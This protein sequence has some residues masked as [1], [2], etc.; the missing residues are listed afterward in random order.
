MLG[1]TLINPFTKKIFILFTLL[2]IFPSNSGG[3]FL[4]SALGTFAQNATLSNEGEDI[5][6]NSQDNL[7]QNNTS[8][9]ASK[10][11]VDLAGEREEDL[12][13][14]TNPCEKQAGRLQVLELN[15][16]DITDVS[17]DVCV[18]SSIHE[19]YGNTSIV[20]NNTGSANISSFLV[21]T[22]GR[23]LDSSSASNANITLLEDNFLL[24]EPI[25]PLQQ[26]DTLVLELGWKNYSAQELER[27]E[28]Y[29]ISGATIGGISIAPI[30]DWNGRLNP[31]EITIRINFKG[32]G[33]GFVNIN[34]GSTCSSHSQ[35]VCVATTSPLNNAIHIV[36]WPDDDTSLYYRGDPLLTF[37]GDC[38]PSR[39]GNGYTTT[40]EGFSAAD[41]HDVISSDLTCTVAF[42]S[43]HSQYTDVGPAV[44]SFDYNA[45]VEHTP[46]GIIFSLAASSE[47][48]RVYAGTLSGVWRSDD[49][50][51]TWYQ[52]T[53]LQL[54]SGINEFPGALLV[55]N[56]Y[57]IIVSPV[58]SDLVFAT[59]WGDT[60]VHP[61]NG[62]YRSV[63][64]GDTW[65]LVHKFSC[66]SDPA[67]GTNAGQ[68]VF[69]PDDPEMVA[70]AGGCAIAISN[71]GG[72]TWT[73]ARDPNWQ[74]WHVAIGPSE[75][76][77]RR[78]YAAGNNQ[79]WYSENAGTTWARDPLQDFRA[80][81]TFGDA[82]CIHICSAAKILAVEPGHPDHV[83][84]AANW[85][86]NAILI[87]YVDEN[88][89]FHEALS[90]ISPSGEQICGGGSLWLG[91]FSSFSQNGNAQWTQM[92]SNAGH[93]GGTGSGRTFVEAKSVNNGYLLF[94]SGRGTVAVS[95]G[96]P[97]SIDS[98]HSLTA[99]D[100]S[101][102]K[103]NPSNDICF[104]HADP[105]AMAI[106]QDFSITLKE[107]SGV[108]YPYD[109]NKILDRYVDGNIWL[110]ND[111]GIYSSYNGGQRWIFSSG[112]STLL[113]KN[114]AGLKSQGSL[115]AFFFGIADNDNFF[116]W[117][118][119]RSWQDPIIDE[120][121]ASPF[122]S[123]NK[124]PSRVIS[125]GT[126]LHQNQYGT[127]GDAFVLYRSNDPSIYPNAADAGSYLTIPCPQDADG[128]EKTDECFART[129]YYI[130]GYRPVVQTLANEP[131]FPDGDYIMIKK[132]IDGSKVLLRTFFINSINDR[133][134]WNNPTLAFQQGP[135]LPSSAEVAQA[136]GGHS[137]T[138]FYVS[139]PFTSKSLWKWKMGDS[140]W[141]K[142]VPG[143]GAD[144]AYR[145]FV[146]PYNPN[147]IY[148]IDDDGIKRSDDGGNNWSPDIN[149]N[150]AITQNGE[151]S[152][153]KVFDEGWII[154]DMIF[155]SRNP[156]TIFVIGNSGI[157]Y[158]LD[159]N[160]W[161]RLLSTTAIPSH[162]FTAFFDED[163]RSLYVAT[164]GR[165]I[166]RYDN[167]P[168]S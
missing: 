37:G 20:F 148:I 80:V 30:P 152:H 146:S 106:S 83:Y 119:G 85:G 151:F 122:F 19:L 67:D 158:S 164:N 60:R 150:N 138:V 9:N 12:D 159:G 57:D 166:I 58:D 157:F 36:A 64:G 94:F 31:N 109:Q 77:V 14:I 70:A 21:K 32:D 86:N 10:D 142:I 47:G 125:F 73:E 6:R 48:D 167:I 103:L 59:T 29:D 114:L 53:S 101:T 128:N 44:D 50:G 98:W 38:R 97:T 117:D 147:M 63:D 28:S 82:P 111:G 153:L 11:I 18:N 33:D 87:D 51:R 7:L 68:I 129:H 99:A 163:T 45:D 40:D 127:N 95:N 52:L 54:K 168:T 112:L 22:H 124:L 118:G 41:Y 62:V 4:N 102:Q 141:E 139:D 156:S 69:A 15:A 113:L 91:N 116:T 92:K 5:L 162:P 8:L 134:D 66:G 140:D 42:V 79:I 81:A 143:N 13:V 108:T 144:L 135:A 1:E 121:D 105:Q 96:R 2:V 133:S 145:F 161:N 132:N 160:V 123:D 24:V 39:S 71:D 34:A 84:L 155:S 75:G 46:S 154:N 89:T 165:G 104:M 35:A 65:T 72:Q 115:P 131:T 100:I 120:G 43:K 23:T 78:M 88:G 76:S 130:R 136:S 61:M 74:V 93:C 126:R 137:N 17:K 56:V 49:G 16:S 107:P 3:Y 110:G 55:P 25:Q 90:C 26:N 149:L 27:S